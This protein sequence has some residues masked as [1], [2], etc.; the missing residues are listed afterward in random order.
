[1]PRRNSIVPMLAIFTSLLML[2]A[3]PSSTSA[4]PC[5]P[6]TPDASAHTATPAAPADAVRIAV[7]DGEALLWG[8][9]DAAVL[10]VHGAIYDAESWR[11]QAEAMAAEGYRVLAL[12]RIGAEDVLAGI[13]FLRDDC[14]ATRIVVIGASAGAG[15]ALSALAGQPEGIAGLVVLAGSGSVAGLGEFPKLFVASED[16]GLADTMERLAADA[17]GDDNAALILPGSAHAQA[18]FGTDQGPALLDAILE[19]LDRA[20]TSR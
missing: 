19:F 6:A 5:G 14:G 4:N 12:E 8:D 15:G 10:L 17:P 20:T 11:A 3:G 13:D 18:V 16:E 9:G 7:G 2:L 1:M